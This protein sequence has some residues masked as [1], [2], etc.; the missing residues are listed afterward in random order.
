MSYIKI[1]LEILRYLVGIIVSLI[2]ISTIS[3]SHDENNATVSENLDGDNIS[4]DADLPA[5]NITD[6]DNN[7]NGEVGENVDSDN[8]SGK[9]DI[10]SMH[11]ATPLTFFG[12]LILIKIKPNL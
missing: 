8:T 9:W 12:I 11:S 3:C 6:T 5:I 10:V 1:H 4:A 7:I 2:I